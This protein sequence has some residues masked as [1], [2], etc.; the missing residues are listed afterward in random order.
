V[1]CVFLVNQTAVQVQDLKN[2]LVEQVN[3]MFPVP[4]GR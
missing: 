2:K 1:V 4:K 3:E